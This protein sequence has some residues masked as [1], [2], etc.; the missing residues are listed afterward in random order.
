M[1]QKQLLF[2][3][4]LVINFLG[5]AQIN[6]EPALPSASQ[7]VIVTFDSSKES[8]LGYF[9]GDL[10]AHTGVIIEGKD[11]WQHVIESWGNNTTQPKLTNKGN[12]IYELEISP[13]IKSFYSVL[14]GEEAVSYTHLTLP[15]IYS[16]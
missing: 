7:S 5:S 12:G 3:S 10:Y 15:T 8:R 16:V 9:T 6:T 4:L 13:D 11:S 1:F 2:I 14:Q